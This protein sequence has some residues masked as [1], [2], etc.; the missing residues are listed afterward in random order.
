MVWAAGPIS[1]GCLSLTQMSDTPPPPP[2]FGPHVLGPNLGATITCPIG[3]GIHKL[4]VRACVHVCACT[5][6]HANMCVAACH[7][8]LGECACMCVGCLCVIYICMHACLN[9]SLF[10]LYTHYINII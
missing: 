4:Q 1:H 7:L 5:D 2:P 9:Q 10:I 3:C 8:K 6:K